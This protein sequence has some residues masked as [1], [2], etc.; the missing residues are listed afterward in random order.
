MSPSDCPI[1]NG[2]QKI[3]DSNSPCFQAGS[4][5]AWTATQNLGIN[6]QINKNSPSCMNLQ[7]QANQNQGGGSKRKKRINRIKY[8]KSKKRRQKSKRKNK[9][10]T[11]KKL[12]FLSKKY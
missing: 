6:C 10:K 9:R 3:L 12:K 5:N 8:K 2:P 4:E 7:S 1:I 11:N